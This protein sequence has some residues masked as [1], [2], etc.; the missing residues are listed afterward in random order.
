LKQKNKTYTIDGQIIYISNQ[1]TANL[2]NYTPHI[3]GNYNFWKIW[4]EWFSQK[5]PDGTL[6]QA[7][8][9]K[10]VWLIDKGVRRPFTSKTALVSRFNINN[11]ITIGK[12]E[13]E[14]YA[15]GQAIKYPNYTLLIS[16][17]DNV[18]MLIN[19]QLRMFESKQVWQTLGFNPEEFEILDMNDFLNY[20]FGEPITLSSAY[21]AGALLQNKTTGGVYFV[22]DGIKYPL[23]TK[24]VLKINFPKYHLTPVSIGE[25]DKYTT[26]APIKIRDGEIVKPSNETTVYVISDG[27]KRPVISGDVFE[28]LGYQWKNLKVVDPRALL[29]MEL[30]PIIDLDFKK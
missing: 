23:M 26:G 10:G 16:P 12:V 4:H 13:L 28:R 22:Q 2:Y 14:K 8:G 25:L 29:N 27:K 11:V 5:Y 30:G 7:E 6:L 20:E 9:E 19:D 18:Y 21:P 15:I 3:L 17:T 1:A 24:D